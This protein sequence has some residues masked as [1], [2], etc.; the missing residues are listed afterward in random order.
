[1]EREDNISLALDTLF[2]EEEGGMW[3][4]VERR[5]RRREVQ[6]GGKRRKDG[7]RTALGDMEGRLHHRGG[8]HKGMV[9]AGLGLQARREGFPELRGRASHARGRRGRSR[10][11]TRK[12]GVSLTTSTEDHLPWYI[13][14]L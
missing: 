7:V 14:L 11:G 2:G 13:T 4:W 3:Q 9:S 8:W 10:E 12:G 5:V 1:M 6:G